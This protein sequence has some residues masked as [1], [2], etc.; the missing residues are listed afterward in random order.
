MITANKSLIALAIMTT[1]ILTACGGSDAKKETT[2]K[3]DVWVEALAK[4]KSALKKWD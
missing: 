3:G 4:D 1:S 2:T